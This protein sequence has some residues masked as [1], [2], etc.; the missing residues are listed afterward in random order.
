MTVQ[1]IPRDPPADVRT[2]E[3][4]LAEVEMLCRRVRELLGVVATARQE[5]DDTLTHAR[6]ESKTLRDALTQLAHA[7]TLVHT[8]QQEQDRFAET[9]SG[10]RVALERL[11]D[12]AQQA[13]ERANTADEKAA[14]AAR[15]ATEVVERI[16]EV[17]REAGEK[18]ARLRT[19]LDAVERRTRSASTELAAL[20]AKTADAEK[21][22]ET[23]RS[24]AAKSLQSATASAERTTSAI[25]AA[26]SSAEEARQRAA[27]DAASAATAKERV[28]QIAA[29][30][31]AREAQLRT[32]EELMLLQLESAHKRLRATWAAA[33]LATVAALAAITI[34]YLS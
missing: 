29:A 5:A 14:A 18:L 4:A 24:A 15:R 30:V 19:E 17:D 16:S 3:Q 12:E 26:A 21:N 8:V 31:E 10:H 2:D 23:S 34:P 32:A 9:S 1:T 11:R 7:R 33:I 6:R 13:A 27:A 22:L 28:E 25:R 20:Q